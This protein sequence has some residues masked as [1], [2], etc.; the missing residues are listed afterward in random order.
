[1]IVIFDF[2]QPP[3]PVAT[4]ELPAKALTKVDL[5]AETLPTTESR[6][7]ESGKLKGTPRSHAIVF[8]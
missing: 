7:V 1:M 4:T 8:N 2:V 3:D 6:V 5:P